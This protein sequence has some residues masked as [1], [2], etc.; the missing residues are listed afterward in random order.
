MNTITMNLITSKVVQNSTIARELKQNPTVENLNR[1]TV[2]M[3]RNARLLA[4]IKK[5]QDAGQLEWQIKA[6]N[7]GQLDVITDSYKQIRL[8]E[9]TIEELRQTPSDSTWI[10]MVAIHQQNRIL[11]QR[12]EHA[13]VKC[14]IYK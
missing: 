13:K 4:F 2:L 14:N 11:H 8:N 7:A 9:S 10:H 5:E 12:I 3:Q 1:V 6:R